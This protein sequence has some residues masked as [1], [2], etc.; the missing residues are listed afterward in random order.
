MSKVNKNEEGI[1]KY[2][3]YGRATNGYVDDGKNVWS[4]YQL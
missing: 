1:I 3:G 2:M 4:L